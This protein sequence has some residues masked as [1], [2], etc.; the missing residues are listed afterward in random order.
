MKEIS[1]IIP[2]FNEK[3]NIHRLIKNIKKSST[4]SLHC[5]S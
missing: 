1:I 5:N 3:E 4:K 2:T